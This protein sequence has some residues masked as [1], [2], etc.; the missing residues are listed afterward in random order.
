MKRTTLRLGYSRNQVER[1]L[2]FFFIVN[3][4]PRTMIVIVYPKGKKKRNMKV[5]Y[6]SHNET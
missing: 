3:L 2:I 1:L 4:K 5:V 6:G